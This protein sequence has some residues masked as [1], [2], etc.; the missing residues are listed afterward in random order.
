MYEDVHGTLGGDAWLV[1]RV[2]MGEMSNER[3]AWP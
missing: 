3:S 2:T 1:G